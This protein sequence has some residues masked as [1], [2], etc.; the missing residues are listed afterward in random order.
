M[1][2]I[3]SECIKEQKLEPYI[4]KARESGVVFGGGLCY[5]HYVKAALARGRSKK[6]IEVALN[7]VTAAGYKSAPHLK[8]HP[9][10]VKQYKQ[11]IFKES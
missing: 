5:Y 3:C 4:E 9:E 7:Q 8:K 11:G 1:I 10:L 6:Q 2:K